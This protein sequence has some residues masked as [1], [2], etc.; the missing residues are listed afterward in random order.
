MEKR[1]KSIESCLVITV[2]FLV[3]FVWL[4]NPWLLRI[5]LAV[6]LLGV[7]SPW[8]AAKIHA[9]WMLLA[10]A[11]G[12]FNGRV[13]LSVVYFLILTPIAWI[14]RKSG[15]STL[16]LRK[17]PADGSYYNERD[18]RYEPKDLDNTW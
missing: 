15:A 16:Q 1:L 7:F 11:L 3:L 10:R 4:K 9:G 18:H 17:K 2:G 8:A 5:S 13:L 6:G 12:W 14:A